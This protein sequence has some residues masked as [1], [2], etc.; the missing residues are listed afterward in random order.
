MLTVAL[1]VREADLA[2]T[3]AEAVKPC[4]TVD[5]RHDVFVAIGSGETFAAI[6]GLFKSV[7]AKRIA[8]RSDLVQECTA[9]LHAYVGRKDERYLR[10]L[11]EDYLVPYSRVHVVTVAA[12]ERRVGRVAN[13]AQIRPSPFARVSVAAVEERL[14]RTGAGKRC[15]QGSPTSTPTTTVTHV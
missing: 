5:E 6:R 9:W 1:L 14:P 15:K 13:S 3:L 7:A 10:R 2:W 12:A 11:I 4:M 8:L